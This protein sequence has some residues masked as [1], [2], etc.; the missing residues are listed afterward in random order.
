[1]MTWRKNLTTGC[2][3]SAASDTRWID[4]RVNWLLTQ[5]L[6]SFHVF[7]SF[8]VVLNDSL[9]L[10]YLHFCCC[11]QSRFGNLQPHRTPKPQ[12]SHLREC[13]GFFKS[14]IVTS[15]AL[16]KQQGSNIFK[17]W[18]CHQLRYL[19]VAWKAYRTSY[20]SIP[21]ISNMIPAEKMAFLAVQAHAKECARRLETMRG[22]R[23]MA[24][25]V[26]SSTRPLSSREPWVLRSTRSRNRC[27]LQTVC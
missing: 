3:P 10:L 8:E 19:I 4:G 6:A 13:L 2:F 15:I 25:S 22:R 17:C 27:E 12:L 21:N 9:S 11:Y 24:C 18:I 7:Q 26:S 20:I 14:F 16:R 23:T 5:L 1:M